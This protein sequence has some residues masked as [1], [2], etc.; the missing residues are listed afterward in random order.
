MAAYLRFALLRFCSGGTGF[1]GSAPEAS[2]GMALSEAVIS[3]L[4]DSFREVV[5]LPESKKVS[6]AMMPEMN[7]KEALS[8]T[9]SSVCCAMLS[10]NLVTKMM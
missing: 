6:G 10:M 2:G 8:I 1:F 9:K 7:I 4:A 5:Y 3:G